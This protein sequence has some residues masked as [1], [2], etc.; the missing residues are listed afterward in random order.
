MAVLR[1]NGLLLLDNFVFGWNNFIPFLV[2]SDSLLF[3]CVE[4][5]GSK[6]SGCVLPLCVAEINGLTVNFSVSNIWSFFFLRSYFS[7]NTQ[8]FEIE[9]VSDC[10][11]FYCVAFSTA[12]ENGLQ[13]N[14]EEL[15]LKHNIKMRLN[16]LSWTHC[17]WSPCSQTLLLILMIR[18][19]RHSM[20]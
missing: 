6:H 8:M 3:D 15:N 5:G 19:F 20:R 14:D 10:V 11:S 7:P 12:K 2:L 13:Y 16:S 4:L 1:K 18:Q 9:I 17:R